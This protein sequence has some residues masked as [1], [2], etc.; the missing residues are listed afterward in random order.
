M[1]E[2]ITNSGPPLLLWCLTADMRP[3]DRA[4]PQCPEA[5]CTHTPTAALLSFNLR[6][7]H[8]QSLPRRRAAHRALAA[9]LATRALRRPRKSSALALAAAGAAARAL[10][11]RPP[12]LLD[13]SG[14]ELVAPH[15]RQL[16]V[17]ISRQL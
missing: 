4:W 7:A 13:P 6:G 2:T 1:V 14:V 5:P 10:L 17:G 9:A 12:Q 8:R 3:K 11:L 16:A 15:Q